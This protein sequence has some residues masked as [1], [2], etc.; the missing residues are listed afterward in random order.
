MI[1]Q[2]SA[3]QS[4]KR[5]NLHDGQGVIWGAVLLGDYARKSG[6]KMIHDNVLEPGAS[7]GE[8][9]HEGDEE[10]YIILSGRGCMK[11]DGEPREVGA[12]D[13]CLTR[14]GHSHDLTN[15]LEGPMHFL[16]IGVSTPDLYE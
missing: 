16:V 15:S 12:G 9:R 6:F 4:R 11:V 13:M 10:L 8:H 14:S 5:E 7:I 3:V 1:L 2:R